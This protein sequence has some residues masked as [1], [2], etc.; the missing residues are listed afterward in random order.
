MNPMQGWD[1]LYGSFNDGL[2]AAAGVFARRSG[3]AARYNALL[4]R[5]RVV[6]AERDYNA[7][8]YRDVARRHNRLVLEVERLKGIIADLED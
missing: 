2:D 1:T 8:I 7:Q 5:H 3:E 4:A 6:L